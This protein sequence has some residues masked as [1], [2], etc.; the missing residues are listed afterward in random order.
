MAIVEISNL[1]YRYPTSDQFALEEINLEVSEG[2]FLVI[3]GSNGAGKSTLSYTLSGFIPHFFHGNISGNITVAGIDTQKSD[4]DKI[5]QKIGLVFQNTFNQISG[6]KF[7][8]YE[9]IAFGLENLGIP[10]EEMRRRLD[11]IMDLIGISDLANRSPFALSGGQQQRVVLASIMVMK[12]RLLVLDEP[13]SQLDPIG[14]KDVFKVIKNLSSQGMTIV[15][16]EYKTEWIAEFADRVIVLNNG[17]IIRDGTPEDVL[18]DVRLTDYGIQLTR[19]T[20]T[21]YIADQQGIWPKNTRYPI[22]LIEASNS[23]SQALE[24]RKTLSE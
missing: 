23:F 13:T 12:P 20:T 18:S 16:T 4:L 3:I 9:E 1:S 14:T 24:N 19:Y 8:V 6:S 15:M 5:V 10:P 21:A 22:K 7:T 11:W 2:E 17:K